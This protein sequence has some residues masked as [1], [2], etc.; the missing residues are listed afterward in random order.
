MRKV[1]RW[2]FEKWEIV[3][4][5]LNLATLA[6]MFVLIFAAPPHWWGN[7]T[8]VGNST[9]SVALLIGGAPFLVIAGATCFVEMF[10]IAHIIRGERKRWLPFG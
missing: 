5:P 3:L 9:M 8:V 4:V 10:G 1:L 7:P 2:Y 6:A